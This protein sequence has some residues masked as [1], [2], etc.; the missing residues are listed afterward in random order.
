MAQSLFQVG[1]NAGAA[2]GPLLAAFVVLPHGQ[3]G[4]AWF[5]VLAVLAIFIL[6]RVS[7]WYKERLTH[8]KKRAAK[9]AEQS[10]GLSRRQVASAIA[11]LI[12]LVFSK[13]FY[14]ASFTSYYTFYLID[15]FHVSVR[16]SQIHL[17]AFLAA[18]AAGTLVGGPI[19]DR[20]GR[21]AVIWASILGSCPSRCSC[22]MQT[23]SGPAY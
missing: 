10:N 22:L 21:K 7:R 9:H 16:S 2:L 5:S 14:L 8:L 6:N 13:Y 20:I 11:V 19:G 1:G 4:V 3:R 17:F 23:C 18:V 15:R 12:A